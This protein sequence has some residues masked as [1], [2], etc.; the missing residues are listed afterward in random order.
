M[1]LNLIKKLILSFIFLIAFYVG[2]L[3]AV[4]CISDASIQCNVLNSMDDVVVLESAGYR[5][6]R[7]AKIICDGPASYIDALTDGVM[8]TRNLNYNLVGDDKAEVFQKFFA[9]DVDFPEEYYSNPLL[10]ALNMNGYG[11]YW[12]GYDIVLRPLLTFFNYGQLRWLCVITFGVLTVVLA[13][14]MYKTLGVGITIAFGVALTLCKF[15]IIAYCMQFMNMTVLTMLSMIFLLGYWLPKEA[16]NIKRSHLDNF[17]IYIFI[18]AS[19]TIFFDLLTT[20]ILPI[21]LSVLVIM[22]YMHSKYKYSFD[23]MVLL[24]GM[25]VWLLGCISC[26]LAK[27]CLNAIFLNSAILSEAYNQIVLRINAPVTMNDGAVMEA[28]ALYSVMVNLAMLIQPLEFAWLMQL[29]LILLVSLLYFQ[30]IF[31]KYNADKYYAQIMLLFIALPIIWYLLIKNHSQIHF[32]YTY[33]SLMISVVA[34]WLYIK[35][36]IDFKKL[37]AHCKEK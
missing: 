31:P 37:T 12:H 30:F 33:R 1:R 16:D 21:G 9:F 27:W 2:S 14:L 6:K 8:L 35:E 11:R 17:Y 26:W 5:V 3:T 10:R 7:D 28:S 15:P 22:E 36:V 32:W 13:Y 18:L 24:K 19:L 25:F 20:P 4:F 29:L 23:L 34:L